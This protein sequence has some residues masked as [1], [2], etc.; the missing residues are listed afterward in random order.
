MVDIDTHRVIDLI[1]SRDL[2]DVQDWLGTYPNLLV[3]S[4]D[5]SITYKKAITNSHPLAIQV[6]DRFHI[7]KN[8]T[9][10]CKDYLMNYLPLRIE[11]GTVVEEQKVK[12]TPS[13]KNRL[14]TLK[15]KM[16]IAL[17]MKEQGKLKSHICKHLNIDIRVLNKLLLMTTKERNIYYK[18]IKDQRSDDKVTRK[19][20]LVN[21]VRVMNKTMSI[22][23][24]HAE[25]GLARVTIAKYLDPMFI[26]KHGSKG[27]IRQ[28]SLDPYKHEIKKMY[29]QG[30]KSSLIYE[31]I[32]EK[33]YSGSASNL[34]HYCSNLKQEYNKKN[35]T[36]KPTIISTPKYIQRNSLIKML[37]V[38]IDKVAKSNDKDMEY[39]H[40]KY[41]L[42]SKILELVNTFRRILKNKEIAKLDDWIR[43][44]NNLDNSYLNSFINGITRDIEA[45]KNA[46][47]FEY[48]NGLAEGSVN[49]LKVIKRIMYGR[50]SFEL[51]RKKL[52]RLEL[53]RK[54]N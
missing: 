34:R 27:A 26:P 25:L 48:N 36:S 32:F 28:S 37:F 13:Q 4:R 49:K 19:K 10:Y 38:P 43:N 33:G 45:V 54:I 5:G 47:V 12:L 2:I 30:N 16:K 15:E 41:P 21:M 14:L 18:S 6:S 22:R 31:S 50:N 42:F 17:V 7:L 24:I 29:M 52:L 20:E 3:V 11:V 46:I 40:E 23:A 1:E 44:V 35:S 53:R 8:L 9:N 39:V 51:L